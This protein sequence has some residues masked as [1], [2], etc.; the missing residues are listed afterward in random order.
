MADKKL[1]AYVLRANE[2]WINQELLKDCGLV[3]Y[4]LH[5]NYGFRA[6]MV[7]AGKFAPEAFPYLEYVRGLEMDFID[8]DTVEARLKYVKAHAG[9]I[10]LLILYGARPEYAPVVDLYKKLR[11][12][13]K[14]YLAADMDSRWAVQV[15]FANPAFKRMFALC[16]VVAT[17]CRPVQKHIIAKWNVPVNLIRNG[18][19]NFAGVT[20]DDMRKENVILT[21]ARIGT[22]QKQ[23]HVML[24]AFAK[25]AA[26][27]PT[28]TMR[29]VG[30]VEDDF[31]PYVEKYFAEHP[32]LRGRVIFVGLVESKAALMEEYKRAKIFCLSS[33]W[34][35][36][37]PNVTAEAL[38]SGNF[39]VTSAIDAADDMIDGGKCGRVFPVGNVDALADIFREVC[40]NDELI[41]DGE[42]HAVEYAKQNFD[43]EKIVARLH[44]ML[45]GG[46]A[47]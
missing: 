7:G 38:F 24:E 13:G 36:G 23:N 33:H 5:K 12:D 32:N 47:Q 1:G 9:D 41:A 20:F 30:T 34:E 28:W 46:G 29:L 17:S 15:Q 40:T 31:K 25:V 37:A 19:Y 11:P 39:I 6:V 3:P 26:Q 18:W 8:E 35:G 22:F 42:R 16:D 27:L 4:L 45:Y 21:V 14:I 10:D 2:G 44:Y 43:A